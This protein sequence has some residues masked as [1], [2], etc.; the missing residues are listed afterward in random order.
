MKT[1]KQTENEVS[2]HIRPRPA[3][4]L[5]FAIPT[6]TLESLRKIAA[7]REMS[8]EAL[9]KLYVGQGLRQD[10]ARLFSDHIT[11]YATGAVRQETKA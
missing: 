7:S 9:L 5:T 4:A 2:L 11:G 3:E 1:L 6:D 8:V 10:L